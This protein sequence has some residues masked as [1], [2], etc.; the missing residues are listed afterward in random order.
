VKLV[1]FGLSVSSSLYPNWEDVRDTARRRLAEADV[2][3]VTSFCPDAIRAAEEVLGSP[4]RIRCFYDLDPGT[5]LNALRAGQSATYLPERRL[6]DFDLVLSYTG[7]A[8]H[9]S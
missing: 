6:V 5:T 1:V 7:G 8:V 9:P 3:M 2:A 4:A